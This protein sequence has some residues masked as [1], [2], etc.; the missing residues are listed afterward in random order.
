MMQDQSATLADIWKDKWPAE[1]FPKVFVSL[2][3]KQLPSATLL[4]GRGKRQISEWSC[5]AAHPLRKVF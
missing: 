4:L 5:A 1:P 3:Q 2:D